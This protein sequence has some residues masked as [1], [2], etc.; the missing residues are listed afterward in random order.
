VAIEALNNALNHGNGD[1][2]DLSVYQDEEYVYLIVA[3]NGCGFDI[4]QVSHGVG[5]DS[6]QQ[7]VKDLGGNLKIVSK[8]KGGTKITA[9]A[10][11]SG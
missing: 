11:L 2:V 3:D 4:G 5:L 1:R 9:K 8:L 10:P 6:M 7:R